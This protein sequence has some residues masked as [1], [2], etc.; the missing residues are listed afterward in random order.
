MQL[1]NPGVVS[2]TLRKYSLITSESLTGEKDKVHT[3]SLH[4]SIQ[5][6]SKNFL[7]NILRE[8]EKQHLIGEKVID[9]TISK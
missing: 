1:K 8:D 4:R 7:L 3:F 6:L 2:H 5:D 9:K